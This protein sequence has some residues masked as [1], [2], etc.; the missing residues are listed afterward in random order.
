MKIDP[1]IL[2]FVLAKLLSVYNPK[3]IFL[4]GS[5]AWGEPTADS[6]IDLFVILEASDLEMDERIRIG[7]RALSGSGFDVDLLVMTLA[8]LNDRKDHPSTLAHK[9]I[10]KGIKLYEAA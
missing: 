10:T 7:A 6:D 2:D 4:Y 5:Q 3:Q 9:V 8:E 1:K